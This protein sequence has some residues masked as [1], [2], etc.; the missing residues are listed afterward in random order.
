VTLGV[1]AFELYGIKKCSELIAAGREI[2]GVLRVDGAF[3]KRPPA[4][5]HLINEPFASG[6]IYSAVLAAWSYIGLVF[7]CPQHIRRFV[8]LVFIAGLVFSVGY[9][10]FWKW[11]G[12]ISHGLIRLN[13]NILR[14]EEEGDK[15]TLEPLLHP[16]FTIVRASGAQQNRQTFLDAVP[17]NKGRGRKA[18]RVEV[19]VYGER[20]VFT[21]RVTATVEKDGQSIIGSFWNTRLFMWQGKCWQCVSWQVMKI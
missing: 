19:R 6:V 11:R 3:T 12:K 16:E 14:A 1:F 10:H 17:A 9:D 4:I 20:A 2:E 21:C 13:Q 8:P 5:L 15:A 18:D 7:G